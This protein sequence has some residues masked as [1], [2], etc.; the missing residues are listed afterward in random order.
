MN[1][2]I[3][4]NQVLLLAVVSTVLFVLFTVI[5]AGGPSVSTVDA[6]RWEWC[7]LALWFGLGVQSLGFWILVNREAARRR[8]TIRVRTY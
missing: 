2:W 4:R 8:P 3:D 6:N 1:A 7:A 5:L